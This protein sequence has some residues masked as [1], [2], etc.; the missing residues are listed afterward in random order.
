MRTL[1]AIALLFSLFPF[2]SN[3]Q[4]NHPE[5]QNPLINQINR[6]KMH[7]YFVPHKSKDAALKNENDKRMSLNGTWKFCFS[8]NP[9][10]RP[11]SFFKKGFSTKTWKN[12]Q[13]PGSW[14]LQGFDSP[15]Y[16]DVQYPFPARPPFVPTEY[17]PVGSYI[18]E[19][20]VPN[21]WNGEDIILHFDGVESAFYCWINGKLA[22]YS[23]DSRLP[24]EFNITNH[25]K[26]GKNTIAVEV[27]RYSDGSYLEC[28][29]YW[30]YSGIE[31]NVWLVSRPK[32]R[33]QDF[34][35]NAQLCNGYKDGSFGLTLTLNDGKQAGST[36]ALVEVYD[37]KNQKIFSEKKPF[38][39]GNTSISF[40]K[41]FSNV[42]PWTAETPSLYTLVVSTLSSSSKVSE[43]FSHHF[44]FR[45]VEMKNGQLLVNGVP[46][47]IRGVNRHEHDPYKGR[48]ISVESMVQDIKLM[49]QFN[50][51]AVRC[52]HYPNYSEW[53]ELCNK[54]GLYV[55]DEANLESHGMEA[56]DMDSLTRHPD[57]KVPFH[58]RMERM[59]ERDKNNTAI[60]TWSLGN[61][62][63]YGPN[64]EDI[65]HWTKKR[66]NSR[67]VQ[68]E[69]GGMKGLSDIY[70]PMY[71]RIPA[72]RWHTNERQ[73]R[74]LIMC[75]YAHAM[76]NSNGNIKDYWELINK[77]DQLQGGFIWDWVDQTFAKKD[78]KGNNIW[79][80]GGDMGYVGVKNDSNFCANGL[81]AA[82]RTLHPH[83]W[84]V[85]KV[86]QN[87]H[88]E[89]V[90]FAANKVKIS[91]CFDFIDLSH[92]DFS[93]VV[94]GNGKAVASGKIDMPTIKAHQSAIVNINLPEIKPSAD[95]E[96]F[97]TIEA[98]T[99]K[100]DDL[101][102]QGH[103]VA[104]EQYKLP[105]EAEKSTATTADGKVDL[106]ESSSSI[107]VAG[108][109]FAATFAKDN[110]E[111]KSLKYGGKE[112]ILEG[113]QPNFWRAFTDND[114]SNAMPVR[115]AI[116]K[117]AGS[118]LVLNKIEKSTSTSQVSLTMSYTAPKIESQIDVRYDIQANGAI[119][120]SYS[121]TPGGKALPEMPRVGMR[122]VLKG[123]YDEMEWFGRG[124]HENYNDRNSGA[125]ID[126]YK[127]SVWEQF[128]P[129]NRA[130]ET[131]NKT[132]VRWMSLKNKKGEGLLI[133][134]EQP[135][136]VS[137]WN[138]PME[139]IEY[140]PF[141]IMRKHGGSVE[142][143]DMV[144]VNLDLE[145]QGVGGDTTWGAKAHSEYTI[146]PN[147]K[148]YS[149]TITPIIPTL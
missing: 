127:A 46:I 94:K 20:S 44:G 74:P 23:E 37:A 77:Y 90:P 95:T 144:W 7:A 29:D 138:F 40:S 60:I 113:L 85:K 36:A 27:Y 52:S 47:K 81:V 51:N 136:N 129:Y 108:N 33:I 146:T 141:D 8:K 70:C 78:E 91:N 50:I 99:K 116:W 72:L 106:T 42:R 6:E 14:E 10:S 117:D 134:A 119:K 83:I 122:M 48:S 5:W 130:Q 71:A 140:V 69:G 124:P 118:T 76:G 55:V 131:A 109:G 65:Y 114:V 12:I 89:S 103:I 38:E 143:K 73:T 102:P 17:N 123:E 30:R 132:D 139:A 93:W 28:Q 86:Y 16:T 100:A 75:E 35:I 41:M 34:E 31:R 66:D 63:G 24:A 92:L 22:G 148:S 121:F 107:T 82:D 96:Y 11:A 67:P 135:I 104:W 26:K 49:K 43:V 4:V 59:V 97:I 101:L 1:I 13:V 25:L 111:I 145:V 21:D 105:V 53:Y 126:L 115:C 15:I 120:V 64:F 87:V 112:Y 3:A 2:S 79:A 84:E 9:A 68:Y 39:S 32:V 57:W 61:E 19:F 98:T 142:K 125:A 45:T 62:S 133:K 128:F 147:A 58:E 88:F 56:L 80:Y 110:G 18:R 137:C 149:F 54:Y